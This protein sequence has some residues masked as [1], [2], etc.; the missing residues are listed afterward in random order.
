ME[1]TSG[2]LS[3]PGIS[4]EFAPTNMPQQIG[5]SE[6]DGGILAAMTRCLLKDTGLSSFL[7]SKLLFTAAY[8][9]NNRVPHSA[10]GITTP[11]KKLYAVEADISHLRVIEARA[12]VNVES[13]TKTMADKALELSL[14]CCS[15]R[16]KYYHIYNP[17]TKQVVMESGTSCSSGLY[18]LCPSTG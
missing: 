12:F 6:R 8:L 14:C 18:T 10:L 15:P 4:H 13:Q 1:G 3:H 11:Y 5:I 17:A 2:L 9:L 7:W 16:Y